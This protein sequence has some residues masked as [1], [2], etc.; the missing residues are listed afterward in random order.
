MKPIDLS[1]IFT[2]RY[3]FPQACL[4]T[5]RHKNIVKF[6]GA[7]ADPPDCFLVTEFCSNGSLYHWLEKHQLPL[8]VV[9]TWA[10]DVAEGM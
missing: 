4:E 8:E 1:L 2:L 5:L 10:K 7:H 3:L 9:L 6:Y